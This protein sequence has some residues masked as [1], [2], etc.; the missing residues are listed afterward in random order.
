MEFVT[1]DG[2]LKHVPPTHYKHH[3]IGTLLPVK[4]PNEWIIYE[5]DA[6]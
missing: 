3:E 1:S 5:E 2:E 4:D 6:A